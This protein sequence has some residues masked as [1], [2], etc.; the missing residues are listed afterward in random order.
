MARLIVSPEASTDIDEILDWLE[1]EAGKAVALR[2]VERFRTAFSHLMSF[3]EIGARRRKL[4]ADIRIWAIAPYVIFYQFAAN[5]ET[6]TVV[7]ILH[8]RRDI[9]GR[10]SRDPIG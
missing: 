2:Y 3:P 8:S 5:T 4:H 1:R 6:V 9:T 7:R 10:L